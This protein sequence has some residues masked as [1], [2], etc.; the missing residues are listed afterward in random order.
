MIRL[1]IRVR[2]EQAEIALAELLELVPDGVEEIDLGDEIEYAVY[3]APGELPQLP[4]LQAAV[5][6]ALVD[7]STTEVPDD[8]SERWKL[9]HRPL[10]VSQRLYVRPPWEPARPDLIDLVIDPGQAFGTGAHAT[11]RLVLELLLEVPNPQ[12]RLVDLGAGSGVLGLAGAK[13]GFCPVLAVDNDPRSLAATSDNARANK[14]KIDLARVDLKRDP[15]PSAPT[16]LANLVTP[17]LIELAPR[18]PNPLPRC[19]IVSGVLSTEASRV[20]E[21]FAARGMA[22][23]SSREQNEWTAIVLVPQSGLG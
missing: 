22:V 17:L 16:V 12:G 23:K 11:T 1:A 2:R 18:L 20:A 21:A 19:L 10:V 15:I 3:G 14:V 4:A 13:I 5:G 7:V 6:G 9:F 8:W